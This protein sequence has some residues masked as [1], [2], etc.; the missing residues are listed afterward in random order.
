[1]AEPPERPAPPELHLLSGGA[2]HGLVSRL[3]DDF[4]RQ[5]GHRIAGRFNAVG[6]MRDQ[7]LAG[8]PC[9]LL[10]LTRSLIDQLQASGHVR[11]GSARDLGRVRT[12]VALQTGAAPLAVNSPETLK[13]ALLAA[14]GVYFPD[15]VQ[16]TAG[17]HFMKVLRELGIADTLAERLRP[18]PNGATAMQ[19]LAAASG[20]GLIGCTQVTEILNTPGVQ[21][22]APLPAAFE[23]ATV[24]T[25]AVATHAGSPEAASTLIEML[26]SEEHA[27]LRQALGFA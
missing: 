12:G 25:A 27:D 13:A 3:Q 7:L 5:T 26:S 9:D 19:A 4:S 6:V 11:P 17:I 10:I 1:M 22:L 8:A 16:A 20:P 15:P 2:A 23:L 14:Q 18:F 21:L 24:Y